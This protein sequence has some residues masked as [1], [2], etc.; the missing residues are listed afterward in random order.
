MLEPIMKV[1]VVTPEEYMGDVIGDLNRRRGQIMGMEDDAGG[2]DGHRRG[3]AVRDV[4]LRDHGALD[5][6]G[7]RDLHHGVRQ[8]RWK[9]RRTLPTTIIK[10]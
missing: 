9:C 5:E 1:E 6:P 10:K 2:Q 8:V 4:R 3:A 7:P